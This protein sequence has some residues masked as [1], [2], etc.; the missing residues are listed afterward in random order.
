[1]D[2]NP[3]NNTLFGSIAGTEGTSVEG[4]K[5]I[6]GSIHDAGILADK[7]RNRKSNNNNNENI[8]INEIIYFKMKLNN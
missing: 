5:G 3:N 4:S 1:M 8:L 7:E 2:I 6:T